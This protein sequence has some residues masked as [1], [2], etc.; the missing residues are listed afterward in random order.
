MCSTQA[1]RRCIT[2]AARTLK[3]VMALSNISWGME[4]VQA[5]GWHVQAKGWHVQAKGWHVQAK[6]WHV[7]AKGWHV[8]AKGW[9]VQAKG[10]HVQAKGAK[11]WQ[12]KGAK[13]WHV[14]VQ[15]KGWHVRPEMSLS[16][17]KWRW[18]IRVKHWSYAVLLH[19]GLINHSIFSHFSLL[20]QCRDE[21]SYWFNVPSCFTVTGGPSAFS[22]Q[23]CNYDPTRIK[24]SLFSH[25]V[26]NT[27]AHEAEPESKS[28]YDVFLHDLRWKFASSLKNI[29][30][31][32][33]GW[34]SIPWLMFCLKPRLSALFAS[35]WSCKIFI[36]YGNSWRP[37]CSMS[38]TEPLERQ[39]SCGDP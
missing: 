6:G 19:P 25:Y 29:K 24:Q 8:Q 4:N 16:L 9:H 36:L 3:S 17:G 7:Q 38:I 15:A 28:A 35:H 20:P 13:G 32:K 2:L 1:P 23:Q 27:D 26:D 37:W 21:F 33:S 22:H 14:N 11:G 18:S 34:T 5:K 39:T 30:S 12:A 10:W 31:K